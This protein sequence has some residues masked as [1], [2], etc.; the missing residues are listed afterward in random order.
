VVLLIGLARPTDTAAELAAYGSGA[1]A[2]ATDATA[3][4]SAADQ[5]GEGGD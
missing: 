4:G 5:A 1:A 3:Q 2:S